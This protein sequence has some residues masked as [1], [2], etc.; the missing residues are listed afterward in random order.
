MYPWSLVFFCSLVYGKLTS[1]C[2]GISDC[3]QTRSRKLSGKS[4]NWKCVFKAHYLHSFHFLNIYC[5]NLPQCF[6]WLY[7]SRC[8]RSQCPST[9]PN[10]TLL[11]TTTWPSSHRS[12]SSPTRRRP[13]SP[14]S[15]QPPSIQRSKSKSGSPLRGSNKASA[16]LLRR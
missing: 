15:P 13:S 1:P 8:R 14:G 6:C 11:W 5:L 12:T 4:P 7:I 2:P 9:Q 3:I 10:T 16:G